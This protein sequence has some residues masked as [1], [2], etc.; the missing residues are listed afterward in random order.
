MPSDRKFLETLDA[1]ANWLFTPEGLTPHGFC[2]LWQPGLIWTY[3]ISDVMIGIAYFTIP[4]AIFYFAKHRHDLIFRPVLW[5]FAAFILLCGVTHWLDVVTLWAPAYGLEGIAKATTAAVSV[6]T[7]IALWRLMP[8]ALALPS[9]AQLQAANAALRENEAR[10]RAGFKN[11]PAPLHTMNENGRITAISTSWLSLLGYSRDEVVGRSIN[12]LL[13]P[14]SPV[15]SEND[16]ANLIAEGEARD[17]DRRFIRKDGEVIDTLVSARVERRD[18]LT[19]IVCAITDITARRRAEK[20]LRATEEHLHQMQKIDALGQLTGGI[21][22]DI[23]N[24]LQGVSGS[25]ELMERRIA[26]GRGNEVGRYADAARQSLE[27]AASLTNRMLAFARRQTLQPKPVDPD[28]LVNGMAELISRSLGPSVELELRLHDGVWKVLCDANQLENALLNLAI[29]ARDAMPEGGAFTIATADRPLTSADLADQPEAQPGAYIEI[30]ATD[31]GCGMTADV[32]SRVFEPFFTT[33]PIGQG[34]GLG[35]SQLQGFVRQ[36]G[37]VVRVESTPGVGTTIRMFLPRHDEADGEG[38]CLAA[39]AEAAPVG[40]LGREAVGAKILVVEDESALRAQIVDA[41]TDLNYEV[42]EA[43]D[44]VSGLQIIRTLGPIHLIITDVGLPGMNGRQ[45]ADAARE[46]R[47]NA[48]VLFITGYA[49][50]A[51]EKMTLPNGMEVMSKPFD[52]STLAARVNAM[53]DRERAARHS[54]M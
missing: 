48:P 36:S 46:I 8:K 25:L 30:S 5:L 49:G 28:A 12:T 16:F 45:F 1:V 4:L 37:G 27:R 38:D 22:H 35:L 41:L 17:V 43:E 51:F 23:N 44:G 53:L 39:D 24:M 29:N 7:A 19:W 2:L 50:M 3:A 40:P 9:A 20:A 54:S 26:Q 18:E 42:R 15:W 14:G 34:T 21:A 10:Y 32:L 6:V 33:K 52:L 11:S 47:P 13:A 31:T